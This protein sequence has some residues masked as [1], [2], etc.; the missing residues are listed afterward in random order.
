MIWP[1][2]RR[3]PRRHRDRARPV[4]PC[5]SAG[6]HPHAG[7]DR[8]G[9]GARTAA[10][11]AGIDPRGWIADSVDS[12]SDAV[13]DIYGQPMAPPLPG[14]KKKKAGDEEDDSNMG[15]IAAAAAAALLL[16]K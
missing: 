1:F 13:G 7:P 5:R 12:V 8:Q 16:M 10:Y 4:G 15:L 9:A 6:E 2:H 11:E 3:R 14:K